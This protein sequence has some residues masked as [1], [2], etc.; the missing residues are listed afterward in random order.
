[1]HRYKLRPGYYSGTLL[2][3]MMPD[4]P[5]I[6]NEDFFD[7]LLGAIKQINAKLVT[8]Q[9]LWMND[10]VLLTFNSDMGSFTASKDIWGIVFIMADG[11]QEVLLKIDAMLQESSLFLQELVDYKQ[12]S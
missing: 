8:I 10:E 1:M 2:I 9:D 4:P 6:A 3:E 12:Y 5:D 11:N 7:Q